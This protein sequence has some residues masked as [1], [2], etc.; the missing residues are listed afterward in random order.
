M[1]LTPINLPCEW[2]HELVTLGVIQEVNA[3]LTQANLTPIGRAQPFALG[4]GTLMNQAWIDDL[5]AKTPPAYAGVTLDG[6]WETRPAGVYF[7]CFDRR[8]HVR[9][10]T[11]SPTPT[12]P[13]RWV[14]GIDYAAADRAYGQCAALCQVQ[15]IAKQG[16]VEDWIVVADL[17]A[18]D[19]TASTDTFAAE[20]VAMLG[21][22][23]LH[24][25][26]LASAYTSKS[27]TYQPI[28]TS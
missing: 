15:A 6:D 2:L 18:V 27:S 12:A 11:L 8:K 5:R 10:A 7:R 4:D 23:G 20:V 26:Q 17:V 9:E 21:R 25:R 14:L 3:P 16:K 19:G 13:V 28:P 22:H 1:T 24:W